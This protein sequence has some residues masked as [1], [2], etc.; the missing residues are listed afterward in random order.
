MAGSSSAPSR[1]STR[2]CSCRAS[3]SC[4]CSARNRRMASSRGKNAPETPECP[5]ASENPPDAS[6]WLLR[7]LARDL[8]VS[9][10]PP[11]PVPPDRKPTPRRS[12]SRESCA[13]AKVNAEPSAPPGAWLRASTW[14]TCLRSMASS[15]SASARPDSVTCMSA[16]SEDDLASAASCCAISN[17]AS[18]SGATASSAS[19][20]SPANR[21]VHVFSLSHVA[22]SSLMRAATCPRKSMASSRTRISGEL[23]PWL[24][25]SCAQRLR[26]IRLATGHS[27]MFSAVSRSDTRFCISALMSISCAR[28]ECHPLSSSFQK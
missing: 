14:R 21:S 10:S 1:R 16:E 4:C 17:A 8:Y 9:R 26:S 6:T 22:V 19:S 25:R 11:T 28:A 27:G 7:T 24:D 3:G 20:T 12:A 18:V 5:A 2:M 15:T 23:M 13:S